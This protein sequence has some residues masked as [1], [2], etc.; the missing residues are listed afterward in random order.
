M[1]KKFPI[2]ALYFVI[3]L[4]FLWLILWW[5]GLNE[6]DLRNQ[7]FLQNAQISVSSE[8]SRGGFPSFYRFRYPQ[9]RLGDNE[10]NAQWGRFWV[11]WPYRDCS[12][13]IMRFDEAIELQL[14][15]Q[16]VQILASP[17]RAQ[18]DLDT[19]NQPISGLLEGHDA[20]I[21]HNNKSYDFEKIVLAFD[22]DRTEPWGARL[23]WN[24]QNMV[25]TAQSPELLLKEIISS[26]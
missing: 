3:G 6:A 18:I 17:M 15:D 25:I 9:G 7:S 8:P 26:Q 23:S 24:D 22:P 2:Y 10:I 14:E 16:P 21:T 1:M 20:R 12:C 5:H 13:A 4:F 11:F 19:K